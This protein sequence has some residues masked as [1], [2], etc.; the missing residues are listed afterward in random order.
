MR[1]EMLES[2][3]EKRVLLYAW[4]RP[5]RGLKRFLWGS[6]NALI[7]ILFFVKVLKEPLLPYV[8]VIRW[9]TVSMY[10]VSM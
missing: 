4:V 10:F 1:K 7:F 8:L 3:E 6:L 2:I 9:L 5:V